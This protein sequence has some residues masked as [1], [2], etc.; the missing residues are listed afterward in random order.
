MNPNGAA[1]RIRPLI[2]IGVSNVI[3]FLAPSVVVFPSTIT[4]FVTRPSISG[5]KRSV[6]V[7]N[8]VIGQFVKLERR[9]I[10]VITNDQPKGIHML[11]LHFVTDSQDAYQSYMSR[12]CKCLKLSFLS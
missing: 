3:I 7:D 1:R 11:P 6:K 12:Y 10:E 8:P 5:A 4:T 2:S 9:M